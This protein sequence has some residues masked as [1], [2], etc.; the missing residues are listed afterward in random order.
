MDTSTIQPLHLDDKN[1]TETISKGVTIVD[2]YA[3]WCGPCRAMA[4]NFEAASKEI[5]NVIFAKLDVDAAGT[6]AEKYGVMS[7]PTLIVFK[8]GQVVK[9]KSGLQTKEGILEMVKNI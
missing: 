2:F 9:N 8:D 6:I 4:P 7:I 5:K 3:D 1:F